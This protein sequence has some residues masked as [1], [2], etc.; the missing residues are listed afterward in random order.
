M[1]R[2]IKR[3]EI[4]ESLNTVDLTDKGLSTPEYMNLRDEVPFIEGMKASFKGPEVP[5]EKILG[6]EK[7]T[8]YIVGGIAVVVLIVIAVMVLRKDPEAESGS[9]KGGDYPGPDKAPKMTF[10]GLNARKRAT[11]NQVS[12][13]MHSKPN[14]LLMK[15]N[16]T[17]RPVKGEGDLMKMAMNQTECAPCDI[18]EPLRG[19]VNLPKSTMDAL[20]TTLINPQ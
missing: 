17:F 3:G 9:L 20:L 19:S 16:N 10:L 7:K 11:N 4:C 12:N 2:I 13:N 5:S 6:M 18:D 14:P 8:A 15:I 1:K